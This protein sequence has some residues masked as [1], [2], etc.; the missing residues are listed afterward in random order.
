MS[1]A[2]AERTGVNIGSAV[3]CT[4]VLVDDLYTAACCVDDAC[5]SEA[6]VVK[7]YNVAGVQVGDRTVVLFLVSEAARQA[8]DERVSVSVPGCCGPPFGEIKAVY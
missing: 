7:G 8:V 4:G 5:V 6:A 2:S 3:H 1:I